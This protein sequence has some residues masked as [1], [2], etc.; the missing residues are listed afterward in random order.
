MSAASDK[1]E[2]DVAANLDKMVKSAFGKSAFAERPSLPTTYS[3]VRMTVPGKGK[4]WCEVK[5]NHTDNLSN[6]RVFYKNGTWQVSDK[7]KSRNAAA[8]TC[9]L[10]NESKQTK[11]WVKDLADSC[12]INYKTIWIP[13]TSGP[14][15]SAG[16]KGFE[17][18][19]SHKMMIAYFKQIK[20]SNTAATQ[21]I[22]EEPG[23]D[24]GDLVTIHYLEGKSEPAYYMQSGDDFYKIGSR[25]PLGCKGVP[26]FGGNG[27]LKVR[28]GIRTTYYEIQPEIKI[29]PSSL[30]NSRFSIAPG[31]S[32]KNPFA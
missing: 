20:L 16:K 26:Q 6:T 21:Y 5:M 25:N 9:R 32:K 3:D 22:V 30:K 12:G 1:Y 7:A 29:D 2:K 18:V 13:T 4:V 27:N 19:V 11:Q 23:Y 14:I 28:V 17:D 8:E 15:K 31:T 24:I 10:L